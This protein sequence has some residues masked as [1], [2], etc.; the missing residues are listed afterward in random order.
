MFSAEFAKY[1]HAHKCIFFLTSKN[2][3]R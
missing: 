2:K 1:I 3:H